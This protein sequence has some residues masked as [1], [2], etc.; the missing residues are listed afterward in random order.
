ML[1]FHVLVDV[2]VD[3][4]GL[5][6]CAVGGDDEVVCVVEYVVQVEFDDVLCFD[7]RRVV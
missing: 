1:F 3:C 5:V 6:V 4:F 2:V 7:V